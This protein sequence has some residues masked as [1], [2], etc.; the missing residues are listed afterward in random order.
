MEASCSRG[1]NFAVCSCCAI[2]FPLRVFPIICVACLRAFVGFEPTTF[3]LLSLSLTLSLSLHLSLSLP[4][5]ILIFFLALCR[6]PSSGR[7]CPR[8]ACVWP[9]SSL[10]SAVRGA[11]LMSRGRGLNQ[12]SQGVLYSSVS[13]P[14]TKDAT[15][16]RRL[17][18]PSLIPFQQAL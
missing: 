16:T 18:P 5:Q 4:F 11:G 6:P 14:A 7:A 9:S 12:A 1:D 15:C 8:P 17:P 3:R 10:G 13:G 2:Q